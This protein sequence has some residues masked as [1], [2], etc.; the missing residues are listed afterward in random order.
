[1]RSLPLW[2]SG[3][4]A[5]GGSRAWL[6]C[7]VVRPAG[8]MDEEASAHCAAVQPYAWLG[9]CATIMENTPTKPS[10]TVAKNTDLRG[11]LAKSS[12]DEGWGSK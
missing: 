12:Q 11:M 2:R 4:A 5:V 8:L 10:L 6:S 3:T 9:E 1:M 7:Q